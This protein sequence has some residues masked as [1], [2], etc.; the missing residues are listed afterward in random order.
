MATPPG[1]DRFCPRGRFS[2]ITVKTRKIEFPWQKS[3]R[4]PPLQKKKPFFAKKVSL[5]N[6][7]ERKNRWISLIFS[8]NF[9]DFVFAWFRLESR[10]RAKNVFS[11]P[12]FAAIFATLAE[13]K[14]RIILGKVENR[15][16]RGGGGPEGGPKLRL[17]TVQGVLAKY[18]VFARLSNFLG[19]L[20]L[21]LGG[22]SKKRPPKKA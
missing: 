18:F 20:G 8:A 7:A 2:I 21:K 9:L 4:D 15:S 16:G 12:H 11:T 3:S 5:Q 14:T 13:K 22:K 1:R 10:Q 19:Q 17:K 6:S